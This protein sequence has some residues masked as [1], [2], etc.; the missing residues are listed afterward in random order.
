M[1][2][3]SEAP[4]SALCARFAHLQAHPQRQH[5]TH[6]GWQCL[7]RSYH[8]VLFCPKMCQNVAVPRPL[9]YHPDGMFITCHL[10]ARH[11]PAAVHTCRSTSVWA[12]ELLHALV[13]TSALHSWY[14]A[15]PCGRF[16]FTLGAD[17]R[18]GRVRCGVP[19][20]PTPSRT[21]VRPHGVAWGVPSLPHHAVR[22]CG[23]AWGVPPR[24]R[25]VRR[26][27]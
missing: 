9:K 3:A 26:A 21:P 1:R 16:R 6:P 14:I 19:A 24:T 5:N 20:L 18:R 17:V 23:V 25:P 27:I 4:A 10:M 12:A 8:P 13:C 7:E 11:H 22:P 2:A 15:A